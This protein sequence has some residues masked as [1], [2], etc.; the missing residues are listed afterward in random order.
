MANSLREQIAEAAKAVIEPMF[1]QPG[2]IVYRSLLTPLARSVNAAAKVDW[3]QE[4]GQRLTGSGDECALDLHVAVM[5]RAQDGAEAIVDGYMVQAHAL[6]MADR[7]LGGLCEEIELVAAGKT[8]AANEQE[9]VEIAHV[10]RV[11]YRHKTNDL[12]QK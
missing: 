5:V 4:Q 12:T 10:Y 1:T 7:R 6:L 2:E 9:V 11:T 8:G 3:T